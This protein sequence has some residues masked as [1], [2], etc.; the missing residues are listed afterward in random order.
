MGSEKKLHTV[1][2]GL[3]RAQSESQ[4]VGRVGGVNFR[5]DRLTAH[6]PLE[7]RRHRLA[8]F[9]FVGVRQERM[10]QEFRRGRS[11]GRYHLERQLDEILT[12]V[13][14]LHGDDG[15]ALLL[16]HLEHG[17]HRGLDLTEGRLP[18]S[19]FNH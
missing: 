9:S 10:L 15:M 19:H 8:M 17:R 16:S 12:G 14:E 2:R 11:V 4:I 5:R 18:V 1:C 3:D 7:G 6:Q 13:A